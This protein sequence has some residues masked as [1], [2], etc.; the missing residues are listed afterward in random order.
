M[1]GCEALNV[2]L[3]FFKLTTTAIYAY[4]LS[5]G[6]SHAESIIAPGKCAFTV[7]SRQTLSEVKSYI[8]N[9]LLSSHKPYLRVAQTDNG[10]YAITVGDV[11]KDSFNDIKRDLVSR[12]EAPSDS[13]C[14]DGSKYARTIPPD[15]YLRDS[16]PTRNNPQDAP[17]DNTR[18]VYV[19]GSR[20][21]LHE[22]PRGSSSTVTFMRH[23]APVTFIEQDGSWVKVREHGFG[24]VGW[25]GEKFLVASQDDLKSSTDSV[26]NH[27]EGMA[28]GA[29]L[30][31]GLIACGLGG[32][33]GE[34]CFGGGDT[35]PSKIAVKNSCQMDDVKIAIHYLNTDG[36][37]RT[38]AWWEFEYRE[39]ANL[40]YNDDTL[41][42]NNRIVYF[43]AE[44]LDGEMSWE[45][46]NVIEFGDNDLYMRKYESNSD[47]ININ[48]TCN[49]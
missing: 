17:A 33:V 25:V 40:V 37:W 46:D 8:S 20:V 16:R 29:A 42:T 26:F 41:W 2:R 1:N 38:R 36:Q 4:L 12:G 18:Y 3:K 30:G 39:E 24:A 34:D 9:N 43:Y 19:P 14:S 13:Y 22:A 10:W 21:I 5:V 32:I 45:G 35:S 6:T 31:I 23:G 28:V 48:L 27:P 44:T 47:S 49:N 15:E 7:A 11:P